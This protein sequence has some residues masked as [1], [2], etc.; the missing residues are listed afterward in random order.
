[1]KIEGHLGNAHEFKLTRAVLLYETKVDSANYA[2]MSV[3]TLHDVSHDEQGRATIEPGE[4]LQP[5]AA[6]DLAI[7]LLGHERMAWIDP[8]IVAMG[9]GGMAWTC[10]AAPRQMWFSVRKRHDSDPESA[11]NT[12]TGEMFPQPTLLFVAK[13]NRLRVLALRLKPGERPT[14]RTP[15]YRAPYFNLNADGDL[16]IGDARIP[17]GIGPSLIPRFE[18][19]FFESNFTHSNVHSGK[20]VSFEG[21]HDAL[22]LS[23]KGKRRFPEDALIRL[24]SGKRK[25]TV[26]HFLK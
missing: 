2:K 13:P 19:A 26:G 20:L 11:L 6:Q 23:L 17:K 21:G 8:K 10:Q 16:C 7:Q 14:A 1:M 24:S 9:V 12:I 15:V 3:A 5:E 18:Q 4:C 25:L 22:W